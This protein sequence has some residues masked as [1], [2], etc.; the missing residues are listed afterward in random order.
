MMSGGTIDIQSDGETFGS[1]CPTNMSGGSISSISKN[2]TAHGV[3]HS[4][5]ATGG[6]IYSKGGYR[7]YG[8]QGEWI[9]YNTLDG[10]VSITAESTNEAADAIAAQAISGSAYYTVK[11]ATITAKAVGGTAKALNPGGW[12]ATNV[13][14][15]TFTATSTHGDSY[16]AYINSDMHYDNG[17]NITGGTFTGGTYGIYT[18]SGAYARIGKNGEGLSI[19][20]PDITGGAYGIGGA[21]FD[22]YDGILKGQIKAY[23]DGVI[24]AI[25]DDTT[26]FI[27]TTVIDGD[28]YDTRYLIPESDVAKIG[29]TMYTSLQKAVNS[30]QSGDKIELIADN[31]IFKTVEIPADK[32]I[33]IETNGWNIIESNPI[34][35]SGKVK[36]QNTNTAKNPTIEYLSSNYFIQNL[37]GGELEIVGIPLKAPNAIDNSGKLTL[38]GVTITS[39]GTAVN[40]ADSLIA[41][42]RTSIS[43]SSYAVYSSGTKVDL[44]DTTLVASSAAY[45]QSNSA[46]STITDSTIT[47]T[48]SNIAGKLDVIDTTVQY[49]ANSVCSFISNTGTGNTIFNNANITFTHNAPSGDFTCETVAINNTN[50]MTFEN[51]STVDDNIVGASGQT[52]YLIR[53][54]GPKLTV[55][56][57]TLTADATGTSANYN[58]RYAIHNNGSDI[59]LEKAT[60]SINHSNSYGLYNQAGNVTITDDSTIESD[61]RVAYGIYI[62]A[63]EITLGE[64]EPVGSEHYGKD[65]AT[66][67]TTYPAITG[68]G[69]ESGVGVKNI[70]GRFNYYDG[71]LTGST[72]AMP[73]TPTNVE[74]LYEPK[75]YTLPNGNQYAVLEWMREQP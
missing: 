38:D 43:G 27:G 60:I 14:G 72:A 68:T 73:E 65:T 33:T 32:D 63:G 22:F 57:S 58:N 19:T 55:K 5:A 17:N 52:N 51:S 6:S 75:F 24:Y 13:S 62:N 46:D 11:D 9:T 21:G 20:T 2:S 29:T 42:N 66:V 49:T 4:L 3:W 53:T 70:A 1:R 34:K 50:E 69:T 30:A 7:A 26:M 44:T 10:G 64:A 16:A 28:N 59:K 15:G 74:Y 48:F 23:E 12:G 54:T 45:Y 18:A 25:A 39:T 40:N 37:A 41:K 56:D 67:S 31:Y 71:I 36:L 47:G 61:G 8:L 35:N